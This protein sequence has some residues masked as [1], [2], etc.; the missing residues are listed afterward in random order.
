MCARN[1]INREPGLLNQSNGRMRNNKGNEILFSCW[2]SPEQHG[3][4][5]E[6]SKLVKLKNSLVTNSKLPVFRSIFLI[7]LLLLGA[8]TSWSQTSTSPTQTVCPGTEPYLVIPGDVNNAFLW[9]ITP[10]VAGTDWTIIPGA[11]GYHISV[12]W[13]N[14]AVPTTYTL[15]LTETTPGPNS[16]STIQT[17]VVTVN[18]LPAATAAS[19]SPVCTGT[20]LT[21][22]GGPAA[23]TTY[24]WTGPNG[25]T[26]TPR[27]RQ[28]QPPLLLLWLAYT[29][30]LSLMQAVVYRSRYYNCGGQHCSARYCFF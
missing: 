18:P 16:C 27:A 23:M 26:S 6:S 12:N 30:L 7:V 24:A 19:N 5:V 14:P 17:V 1:Q 4:E 11:D 21:L 2:G 10:G 20:P 25:F 22:T 13:A 8:A 15:T 3:I 29:S 28:S 9:T